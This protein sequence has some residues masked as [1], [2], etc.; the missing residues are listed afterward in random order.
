MDKEISFI[1]SHGDEDTAN[2]VE[3]SSTE[4]YMPIL[5]DA[6]KGKTSI[7]AVKAMKYKSNCFF[8][9]GNKLVF[10]LFKKPIG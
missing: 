2:F 5:N 10:Y 1:D 6:I 7:D 8:Y 9:S 4:T 3:Y